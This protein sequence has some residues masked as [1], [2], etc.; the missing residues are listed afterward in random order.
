MQT[1]FVIYVFFIKKVVQYIWIEL[2]KPHLNLSE[3]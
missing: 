1:K 3:N 2:Y